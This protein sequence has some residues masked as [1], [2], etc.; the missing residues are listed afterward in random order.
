[1]RAVRSTIKVRFDARESFSI[2][3]P[4]GCIADCLHH[5]SLA[6]MSFGVFTNGPNVSAIFESNEYVMAD[7]IRGVW[8]NVLA[9]QLAVLG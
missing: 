6:L 4:A 9:V 3:N 5:S 7:L 2:P 1:M 8:K